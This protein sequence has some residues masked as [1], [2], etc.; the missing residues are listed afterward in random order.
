MGLAVVEFWACPPGVIVSL[1]R[2]TA[3]DGAV[4]FFM[5]TSDLH[6]AERL[7]PVAYDKGRKVNIKVR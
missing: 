3:H 1:L 7:L 4:Y 5:T 6:S 2:G